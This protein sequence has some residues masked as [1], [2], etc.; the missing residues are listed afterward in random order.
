VRRYGFLLLPCAVSALTS[1]AAAQESGAGAAEPPA[2]PPGAYPPPAYPPP[3]YPPPA[4]PPPGYGYPPPAYPP[5]GYGYPP[6]AYPPPGYGYPP[7]GYGYGAPRPAERPPVEQKP[8]KASRGF[9]LG[10][11]VGLAVPLGLAS[12][13]RG[14]ALN[15][16]YAS[17]FVL[18][19]DLGAKLS[20]SLFIGGY[21]GLGLGAEGSNQRIERFCDDNGSDGENDIE[22]GV[23]GFRLGLLA[24]WYFS[25]SEAIDPW[26]AYGIG[27][28]GQSQ[29]IKDRVVGREETTLASGFEFARLSAGFDWRPGKT[30][31]MG[32]LLE[33]S[34]GSY[35]KTSTR[36]DGEKTFDGDVEDSALHTWVTVAFRGVFFP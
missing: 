22:C 6:P 35:T 5:P 28:E 12:G 1:V 33:A 23:V 24:R 31:G 8:P 26:I 32:P 2:Q 36:V 9:Q 15:E 20:E 17:Q 30:F 34:V 25:P 19:T 21:L 7:P 13:A 4:Y 3:A 11:R 18:E 16:R 10:L 27:Y 29:T 14:D